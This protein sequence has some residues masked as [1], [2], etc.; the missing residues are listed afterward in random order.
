MPRY[1]IDVRSR[2]GLDEDVVGVDLPDLDAA[3]HKALA[4]GQKLCERW[5]EM[6][7]DARYQ[8]T[9]EIVD[10][11]LR[12]VLTVPLSDLEPRIILRP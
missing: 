4:L 10:E 2:F 9:I 11:S 7:T 6:P 8:I 5:M 3:Q 12:T 1:Y